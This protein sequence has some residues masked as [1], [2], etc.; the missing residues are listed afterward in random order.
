MVVHPAS[1]Q[2]PRVR[3]YSGSCQPLFVFDYGT[4]TLSGLPSQTILLTPRVPFT[5]LN[6]SGIATSGLA[7]C[8]F[9]RR[10]LGN[11]VWF[12]F[13]R[14]L[15]CFSS[16]GYLCQAMDSLNSN[17]YLFCWVSPFGN[18]WFNAYLRLPMAYRSL[19]R[20]SS[21]PNAKAFSLCSF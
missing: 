10:Y 20:P 5:V 11:L 4:L 14:L 2:I 1:H 19:S 12:L 3:C 13:L 18:P 17:R 8:P 16:A 15:R 6:P 9:A 21:A 7:S